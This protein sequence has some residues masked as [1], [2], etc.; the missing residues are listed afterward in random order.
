MTTV[1]SAGRSY[2]VLLI[3]QEGGYAVEVPALP[4]CLTQ[5]TNIEQALERAREAIQGH[6]EALESEGEPIPEETEP[7][8]LAVVAV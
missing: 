7:P 8:R 2:T 5:G 3:P 6:I 4:G 1:Q